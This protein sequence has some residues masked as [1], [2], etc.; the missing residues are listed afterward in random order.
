MTTYFNRIPAFET[1]LR[2]YIQ[3]ELLELHVAIPGFIE[4]YYPNSDP[5]APPWADVQPALAQVYFDEADNEVVLPFPVIPNVPI[6]FPEGGGFFFRWPLKAGDPV[7]LIVSQRS[8]D[9][10]KSSDGKTILDPK[11]ARHHHITD[12][13]AIPGGEPAVNPTAASVIDDLIIGKKDGSGE[14][15]VTSGGQIW[16]TTAAMASSLTS[17]N[18]VV[19]QKDL[20]AVVESFNSHGHIGN[21]G[22]PTSGPMLG[23]L[24][25]VPPTSL[26]D[27]PAQANASG[28]VFV[29]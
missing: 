25:A 4:S 1:S 10:W 20:N 17:D 24:G 12:A 27:Y 5:T 28:Q 18:A 21:L 19:R 11:D 26:P 23:P 29:E 13:W 15:H 22:A 3:G 9:A 14:I 2:R 6:L 16:L 7:T 8:L